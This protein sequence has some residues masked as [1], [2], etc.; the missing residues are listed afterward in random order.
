MKCYVIILETFSYLHYFYTQ[1]N[2]NRMQRELYNNMPGSS[3]Y[4]V[5]VTAGPL[6]GGKDADVKYI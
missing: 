3:L 2:N 4:S 1:M 6:R 5:P